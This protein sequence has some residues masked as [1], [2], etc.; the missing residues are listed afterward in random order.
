MALACLFAT[1]A[2]HV[3]LFR[4]LLGILTSHPVGLVAGE[5]FALVAEATVYAL[6]SRPP[7][8][9]RALMASAVANGLSFAGGLFL[10]AV[11]AMG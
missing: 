3:L 10:P 5:A 4:L 9:P 7:N 6:V 2:T 8:L 11:R 1:T